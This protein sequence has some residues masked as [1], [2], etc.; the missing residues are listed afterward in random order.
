VPGR[1]RRPGAGEDPGNLD[2]SRREGLKIV[3]A[4]PAFAPLAARARWHDTRVG[5]RCP[6]AGW[7]VVTS[8][9]TVHLNPLRRGR[10]F[11]WAWVGAHCLLH[12]GFGHLGE[13]PDAAGEDAARDDPAWDGTVL[14]GTG[15]N[16]GARA[17][18]AW[19]LA[20]CLT[21]NKLLAHVGVGLSPSGIGADPRYEHI[22][23][24][25]RSEES[26]A[27][28]LREL[29]DRGTELDLRCAG[30]G[31]ADGDLDTSAVPLP[32]PRPAARPGFTGR[33]AA[34]GA[35]SSASWAQL[36]A[37]G[38]AAVAGSA[39][40][41]VG[42]L[43]RA[44][45]TR[46]Q[47]ALDWFV[48]SYPL[49]GAIADALTLVEDAGICR[50]HGIRIAAISPAAAELYVNPLYWLDEEERRFVIAHELL[51]AGL[52]HDSRAGWRDPWLWNVACDYVI[53][54]WLVEME[55]GTPP[56]GVLH[57]KALRGMSAEE[58]YDKIA[59]DRRR[60]RKIA[61]LRGVGLADVLPGP[62]GPADP[63]RGVELDEFYRRSLADGLGYHQA[64]R[65]G[66]L[67]AGLVEE[68][69]ALAQPPVPWDVEL[70]RW[71]DDHFAPVER[72][73]SYARASRRQSAT[74]DIPRPGW[75]V[76]EELSDGRTFGVLLDTS[77][78]MDI[79]LLGKALGAIASYA[80]ARDV[81]S[82]RVVFCDADAHD[83][84]WMS[85]ADIAGRV[86]VRGRGGTVLQPGVSLLQ[87]APDFPKDGPI[88]I[89]TDG[90]CDRIR[91]SRE[92]AFLIPAGATLP[93]PPRGPVF[94]FS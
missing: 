7:A 79:R 68:I 5:N 69:R 72:R 6:P 26:L 49:L 61:T 54:G 50:T 51:H 9:G 81:L 45:K 30:T 23:E 58:V 28:R 75:H 82:V 59:A 24:A 89:I 21:V 12:L 29:R 47:V 56:D 17:D 84:G 74:P 2:A 27:R 63:V 20:A 11:E 88:L 87:E 55:V 36:L 44:K 35:A 86:R 78:S 14:D 22:A 52:R 70:A 76:P 13:R 64:R 40:D 10:P 57:D 71:F 77:G 41:Q 48:S 91:V 32:P 42:G 43:E 80:A 37:A 85:P 93:F 4:H 39:V 31:G 92:H 53:N 8:D 1:A 66:L 38:L 3:A 90:E 67:P 73:R 83:N 62:L 25:T 18:I 16:G 94:R 15:R 65:R 60:L 46:W 19:N 33:P 34:P